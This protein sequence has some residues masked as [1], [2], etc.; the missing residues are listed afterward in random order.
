MLR[1]DDGQL[2]PVRRRLERRRIV[3]AESATARGAGDRR[4]GRGGDGS[5]LR[6]RLAGETLHQLLERR[7]V[8]NIHLGGVHGSLIQT[9]S[10]ELLKNGEEEEEEEAMVR[11]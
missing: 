4:W 1:P 8:G 11:V 3:D 5:G 10:L 9:S 7:L 2:R 6:R